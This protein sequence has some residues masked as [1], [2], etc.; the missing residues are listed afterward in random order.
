MHVA[1]E[2]RER[3]MVPILW[4]GRDKHTGRNGDL[5][6]VPNQIPGGVAPS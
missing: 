6:A 2:D 1:R 5:Q 4:L 3:D